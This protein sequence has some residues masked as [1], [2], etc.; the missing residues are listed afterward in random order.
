MPTPVRPVLHP[1]DLEWRDHAQGERY[2]ARFAPVAGPLG[3][4]A[5]GGRLVELPPGKRAWPFHHHHANEE[6]VVI[7]S[8]RGVWR[9]GD[10]R[11]E[12]AAGDLLGAPAG[13]PETAHQLIN[14]GTEPLRYLAVSTMIAPDVMGYPDSGKF[15]VM[16]GAAPG[17]SKARRTFEHVGRLADGV[18]YWAG[19]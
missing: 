8:G 1:H 9:Y 19:E 13:G 4:T 5:L 10:A 3:L 17:G 16:A 15:V 12:V 7:L 14:E 6:L 18:D 2:Q 11:H